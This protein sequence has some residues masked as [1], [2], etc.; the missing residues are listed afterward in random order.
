[1]D[2]AKINVIKKTLFGLGE[3]LFGFAFLFLAVY[4]LY[5]GD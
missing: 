1:M 3:F 4:S 5:F 2:E